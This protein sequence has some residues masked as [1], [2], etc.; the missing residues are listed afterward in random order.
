M[1]WEQMQAGELDWWRAFL[2]RPHALERLF[3]LYGY[4]YLGFFFDQFNNLGEVIDFGSGPVS[5]AWIADRPIARVVC[6]D[7]LFDSYSEAGLVFGNAVSA[8]APWVTPPSGGYDTA[9][10]L[11]VLDHAEDPAGVLLAA[12]ASLK[13]DGR[14]LVWSHVNAP[15]DSLHRSLTQE[16]VWGWLEDAGLVVPR[17]ETRPARFGGPMEFLALGIKES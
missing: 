4:R 16:Q 10:V 5:A 12:A 17:T 14:A 9:L 7:P 6:V 15:A 8:A 11:N 3:G 13:L 1:S 2:A